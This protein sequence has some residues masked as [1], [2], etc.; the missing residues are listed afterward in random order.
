MR[1]GAKMALDKLVWIG[2]FCCLSA[3]ALNLFPRVTFE[4]GMNPAAAWALFAFGFF[5][6]LA[7]LAVDWKDA[8][9]KE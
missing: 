5:L 7:A 3:L 9:P 1:E 4:W 2:L 6:I 8:G